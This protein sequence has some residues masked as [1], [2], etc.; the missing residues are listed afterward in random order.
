MPPTHASAAGRESPKGKAAVVGAE[1]PASLDVMAANGAFPK[2]GLGTSTDD[3][4]LR[5]RVYAHVKRYS[6]P[7]WGRSLWETFHTLAFYVLAFTM[8]GTVAGFLLVTLLRVRWFIIFHDCAHDAFFPS[9][10]VNKALG[11]VFGTINHTPLSFWTR[12]HNHHHR[13]RYAQ[14]VGWWGL[15]GGVWCV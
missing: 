8:H 11:L 6:V 15:L 3:V 9:R 5:E 1:T 12:G 13:H 2:E 4:A 14:A 10:T 7:S